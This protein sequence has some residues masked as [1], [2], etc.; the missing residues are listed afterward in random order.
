MSSST[1]AFRGM[2]VCTSFR[3]GTF[4][5]IEAD[6]RVSRVVPLEPEVIR[7]EVE[8][9]LRQW[10]FEPFIFFNGQAVRVKA[11]ALFR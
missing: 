7:V 8:Q 1:F 4:G 2:F 9:A 10:E 11:L 6:G 5:I 3:T